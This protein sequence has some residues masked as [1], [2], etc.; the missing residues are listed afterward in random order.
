MDSSPLAI[1]EQA[2]LAARER[3]LAANA[4]AEEIL[5]AAGLRV[6]AIEAETPDRVAAALQDVRHRH[7]ERADAEARAIEQELADLPALPARGGQDPAFAAAVE[8]V[9]AAVLGEGA[10]G[11][12]ARSAPAPAAASPATGRGS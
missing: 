8:L 9:V 1:L 6:A 10:S 7:D 2:E 5:A 4:E 3:R 11:A 12:V